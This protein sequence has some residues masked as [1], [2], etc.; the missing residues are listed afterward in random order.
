MVSTHLEKNQSKWESSPNRGEKLKKYLKPPPRNPC[1]AVSVLAYTDNS[2]ES[3]CIY[4]EKVLGLS[5]GVMNGPKQQVVSNLA[6]HESI[7]IAFPSTCGGSTSH[8]QLL[9]DLPP[10]YIT[11]I[12][13]GSLCSLI[14]VLLTLPFVH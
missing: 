6:G 8:L 1:C 4:N 3:T 2:N 7:S 13:R 9:H 11:D 14:F 10:C 5:Y 12:I